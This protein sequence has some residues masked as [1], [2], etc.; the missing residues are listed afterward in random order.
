NPGGGEDEFVERGGEELSGANRAERALRRMTEQDEEDGQATN[1]IES[2]N[3]R[4]KRQLRRRRV[5]VP[6]GGGLWTRQRHGRG[7]SR[8]HGGL[9]RLCRHCWPIPR[10]CGVL[11]TI[12]GP[13][14]QHNLSP[15]IDRDNT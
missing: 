11:F 15:M 7:N 8:S 10:I 3:V 6:I 12:G 5:G 13:S 9:I 14:F 4:G 1:A 2:G